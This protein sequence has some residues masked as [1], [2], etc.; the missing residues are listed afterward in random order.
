MKPFDNKKHYDSGRLRHKI[1]FLGDVVT[2]DGYGGSVVTSGVLLDTW[3]GKEDV[4]A[5]TAA[6]LNAGQT[7]YNYFQYF[8]IRNRR[9]FV[10]AKD[11]LLAYDGH[12]YIVRNVT[13][14]DDPCTFLKLLCVASEMALPTVANDLFI[15]GILNDTGILVDEQTYNLA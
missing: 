10:P 7:Q 12:G 1:R 9:G 14:L 15:N 3:A 11:M 13:Q 6:G 8:V 5:Y 2:D 4:S